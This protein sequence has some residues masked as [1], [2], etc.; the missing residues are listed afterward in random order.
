MWNVILEKKI[1]RTLTHEHSTMV[2]QGLY[3]VWSRQK[4]DR[5]TQESSVISM[6]IIFGLRASQILIN[7]S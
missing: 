1:K 5:G 2:L 7:V 6:R 4:I 3:E